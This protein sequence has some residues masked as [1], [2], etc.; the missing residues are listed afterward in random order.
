[1]K[2]LLQILYRYVQICTVQ[3]STVAPP[4]EYKK[5]GKKK[6]GLPATAS[7]TVASRRRSCFLDGL[8]SAMIS[9]LLDFL[10]MAA[11]AGA[12]AIATVVGG[13]GPAVT[14]SGS[15]HEFIFLSFFL[16]KIAH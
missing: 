7:Y 4:T 13:K 5:D 16:Y 8:L 10:V 14:M 6:G 9:I 15:G 1:M 2:V 12:G 11:G 3:Y